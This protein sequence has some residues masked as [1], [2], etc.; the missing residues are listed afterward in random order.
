MSSAANPQTNFI[1]KAYEK[2]AFHFCFIYFVLQ[3]LPLDWKYYQYL[4]SINW[5]H[6]QYTDVFN[7]TRYQPQL[8]AADPSFINWLVIAVIAISGAIIWLFTDV[9]MQTYNSLYYMLRVIV[10]YR[11]A[12][13]IIG[14]GMIKFFPLQSPYPSISNLNTYYSDFSRWKLFS[15]SLGVVPGYETFLGAVEILAG[16]LLLSRKT[17]TIGAVIVIFFT[18]NVFMSNLAYEGGETVYSLY[19]IAMALFLVAFDAG[20]IYSLFA[21]QKPVAPNFF[22]P[23]YAQQWQKNGRLILKSLVIFFFVFWY[24]LKTYSGYQT[25]PYQFPQAAGLKGAAG[26]YNVSEFRINQQNLSYSANDSVRWQDVVFEK[27]A[28]V[29]IRL[30]QQ[31]KPVYT[32]AEAVYADDEKRNYE[33]AGSEGRQYYSYKVDSV[34]HVLALQNKNKNYPNDKLTLHYASFNDGKLVLSGTDQKRDS[35]Y[36]VLDRI[37]KKYLLKEASKGRTQALKL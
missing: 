31:I 12:I 3:A 6:F 5:L 32:N 1:W 23:V 8:F 17:A 27:W 29:S 13:G 19:L 34:N 37:N 26:I 4:F 35:V 30:N 25:H 18:G 7:L 15:M 33:L 10:R 36:A 22:K 20:R 21:T 9:K 28:T 16:L 2:F 11:L 24:G 14:Y